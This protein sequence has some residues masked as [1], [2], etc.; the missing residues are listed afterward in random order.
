MIPCIILC[1]GIIRGG[2]CKET[3]YS[4]NKN[5]HVVEAQK[6]AIETL[7]RLSTWNVSQNR[8]TPSIGS[9]QRALMAYPKEAH[10]GKRETP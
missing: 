1:Q 9:T 8:S 6:G 3:M 5:D 7:N 4:L 2:F 10:R